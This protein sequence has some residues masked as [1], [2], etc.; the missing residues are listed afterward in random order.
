MATAVEQ[1]PTITQTEKQA[2]AAAKKLQQAQQHVYVIEQRK[3]KAAAHNLLVKQINAYV[4]QGYKQAGL[5]LF[6]FTTTDLANY[7]FGRSDKAHLAQAE[8]IQRAVMGLRQTAFTKAAGALIDPKRLANAAGGPG[9][10]ADIRWGIQ[11][12]SEHPEGSHYHGD[13]GSIVDSVFRGLAGVFTLGLSEI[14][15]GGKRLGVSTGVQSLVST[16]LSGGAI[17]SE[18]PSKLVGTVEKIVGT[19]ASLVSGGAAL[20]AAPEVIAGGE[21][22]ARVAAESTVELTASET[23]GTLGTKSLQAARLGIADFAGTTPQAIEVAGVAPAGA[24]LDLPAAQLGLTTEQLFAPASESLLSTTGKLSSTVGKYT[25]AGAAGQQLINA[26]EHGNVSD[27]LNTFLAVAGVPI[28]IPGGTKPP[29]GQPGTPGTPT[30]ADVAGSGFFSGGG[31]NPSAVA[32]P[33]AVNLPMY[34]I[35]IG[36]LVVLGLMLF[37]GKG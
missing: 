20:F 4:I 18:A 25:G 30:R 11:H 7:F 2:N 3:E 5:K 22:G 35:G 10:G 16:T 29:T 1:I 27:I 36:L 34:V 17:Q 37:R 9:W 21:V 15:L 33:A 31:V 28:Q 12:L 14:S 19:G 8:S 13:L 23:F 24:A 26:V 32:D 6:G